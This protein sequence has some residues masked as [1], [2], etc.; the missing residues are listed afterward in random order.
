MIYR[1]CV[2]NFPLLKNCNNTC[3]P[4]LMLNAY[5]HAY[6]VCP[7]YVS[8]DFGLPGILCLHPEGHHG[9]GLQEFRARTRPW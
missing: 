5:A 8:T 6:A 4:F 9:E 3:M 7:C 1:M 2:V